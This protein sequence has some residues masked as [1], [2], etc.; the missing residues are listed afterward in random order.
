MVYRDLNAEEIKAKQEQLSARAAAAVTLT[1]MGKGNKEL[2]QRFLGVW[3]LAIA[4][5]RLEAPELAAYT[6]MT[7]DR[8]IEI[9]SIVGDGSPAA[10]AHAVS[11]GFQIAH[12]YVVKYGKLLGD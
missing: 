7:F 3:E 4:E 10:Y 2:A 9:A 5:E 1:H 6:S 12:D 8:G 11:V